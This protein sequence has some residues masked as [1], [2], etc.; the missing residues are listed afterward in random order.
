[1]RI[2]EYAG[3]EA[4]RPPN[5]LSRLGESG[6]AADLVEA[7]IDLVRHELPRVHQ[8]HEDVLEISLRAFGERVGIEAGLVVDPACV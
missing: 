2:T 3:V 4:W 8:P 7:L 1:L 6:L 5:K